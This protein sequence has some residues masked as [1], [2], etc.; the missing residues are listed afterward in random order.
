VATIR[1]REWKG[2]KL[3]RLLDCVDEKISRISSTWTSS[4][5][6]PLTWGV[7]KIRSRI[8]ANVSM[9]APH[10]SRADG[11]SLAE[12]HGRFALLDEYVSSTT[13]SPP[14]VSGPQVAG[15]SVIGS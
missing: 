7:P 9:S 3:K 15:G 11:A 8:D 2:G 13:C 5:N 14:A 4:R 1:G 12:D 6:A 10:I